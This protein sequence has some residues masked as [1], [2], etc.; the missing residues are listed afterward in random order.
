[1]NRNEAEGINL[2]GEILKKSLFPE[3]QDAFRFLS[4]SIVLKHTRL[5]YYI[6]CF[7]ILYMR[8]LPKEFHLGA[9]EP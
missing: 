8:L 9:Q 7:I 5:T 2:F 3:W 4:S 1:M 6:A